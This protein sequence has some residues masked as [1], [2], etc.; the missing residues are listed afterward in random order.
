MSS[1]HN[2]YIEP[3]DEKSKNSEQTI[4][5]ICDDLLK[6]NNDLFAKNKDVY[7]SDYNKI[8]RLML[9]YTELQSKLKNEESKDYDDEI[10]KLK[11]VIKYEN[12]TINRLFEKIDELENRR[13]S[14]VFKS[15]RDKLEKLKS[16]HDSKCELSGSFEIDLSKAISERENS[17]IVI[18]NI[19]GDMRRIIKTIMMYGFCELTTKVLIMGSVELSDRI[20]RRELM[21]K[22]I[23]MIGS[24]VNVEKTLQSIRNSLIGKGLGDHCAILNSKL[25]GEYTVYYYSGETMTMREIIK[26]RL[27][28]ETLNLLSG[29]K[30]D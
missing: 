20:I 8:Q 28:T 11:H 30:D 9:E 24:A 14:M 25:N 16:S 7:S 26:N 27:K 17:I 21:K 22:H 5:I 12:R 23:P 13:I 3:V 4:S 1:S 6:I 29:D 2:T 19:R 10:N 15:T 18:D